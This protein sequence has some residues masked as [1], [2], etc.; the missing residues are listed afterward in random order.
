MCPMLLMTKAVKTKRR[1]T[2]GKGVAVLTISAVHCGE[3]REEGREG[4]VKE[5]GELKKRIKLFIWERKES[6]A[7]RR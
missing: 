3:R 6:S 4:D 2:M 1:D 7:H 5:R